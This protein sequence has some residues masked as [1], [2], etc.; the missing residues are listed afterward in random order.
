MSG[1]RGW[2]SRLA[3]IGILCISAAPAA[4]QCAPT[5][6]AVV[7][8]G[9][10]AEDSARIGGV[11]GHCRWSL[12]RASRLDGDSGRRV[13]RVLDPA[14][15]TIG[16]T[17]LPESANDGAMWAGRGVNVGISAGV[18]AIYGPWRVTLMPRVVT[19]SNHPFQVLPSG[20][21]ARSP[22]A[23]PWHSNPVSSDL[24]LRFGTGRVTRFD[25]GEST[26]ELGIRGVAA[27]VSTAAQWWGPGIWNALV[28]SNNAAGIPRLYLATDRPV[29][30]PLGDVT[31][32]WQLGVLIESP[33]FDRDVRNDLRSV[34]SAAVTLR[35]AADTGLTVGAARS[36]F[37]SARRFGRI[38]DHWA[39]VFV[40]WHRQSFAAP[41]ERTSDQM[42]SFFA[43]WVFPEARLAAHAEWAKLRVPKSFRDLIVAPQLDQG[44]TIGLEWARPVDSATTIVAR[45]EAT[46]L[47]QTPEQPI[48]ATPEFYASYSVPQGYTQQGQVVGAAI[49]PG[50]S[51]QTLAVSLLRRAAR[52]DFRVGRIRREESAYFRSPAGFSY[53]AHDVSLVS[54]LGARVDSRRV[55]VEASLTGTWRLNYLFQTTD[56]YE[57]SGD[58]DV[59]NL[60]ARLGVVFHV[61]RD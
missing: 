31:G 30:T 37:A 39:D 4:A 52:V 23:S 54:G 34:S 38:G 15:E 9:S 22:F 61:G 27:G 19:A 40:D 6:L 58:F 48:T 46:M 33:F 43:R 24:P 42:T 7:G 35:V 53:K 14:V 8:I 41:V 1:A 26:I 16:N 50:A 12:I 5:R 29:R 57:F 36:V 49:G 10:A 2:E 55:A 13:V 3:A 18:A 59:H 20:N 44:Y 11:L 47:E 56:P 60:S 21:P 17:H 28:L 45:A 25:P 32:V 51:S